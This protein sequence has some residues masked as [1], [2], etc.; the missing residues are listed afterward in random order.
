MKACIS[1]V[2]VTVVDTTKLVNAWRVR[3]HRQQTTLRMEM[4]SQ[5]G[6]GQAEVHTSRGPEYKI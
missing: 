6:A 4:Q 5:S 1:F 3:T 2:V